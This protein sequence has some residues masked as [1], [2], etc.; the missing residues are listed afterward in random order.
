MAALQEGGRRRRKEKG[1][2]QPSSRGDREWTTL[3]LSHTTSR[4]RSPSTKSIIAQR[5]GKGGMFSWQEA[6][7][8]RAS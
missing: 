3:R 7:V 6:C 1:K 4:K 8:T 5:G 2:G